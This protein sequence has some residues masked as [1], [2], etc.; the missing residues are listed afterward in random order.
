ML[1]MNSPTVQAMLNSLPQGV[2]NMPVYY[3][4]QPNIST[5]MQPVPQSTGFSSPYPSP[6]DMVM[7]AGS[8]QQTFSPVPFHTQSRFVGGL[9]PN[10]NYGFQQM[11]AG[12]NNPYMGYGSNMGIPYGFQ[13]MDEDTRR[14]YEAA[15]CNNMTYE[16]HVINQSNL[17]KALSRTVS[18]CLNRS[19]EEAER[20]ERAF[21]VKYK[22]DEAQQQQSYMP[23]R[24]KKTISVQLVQGDEVVYDPK[25]SSYIDPN[26]NARNIAYIDHLIEIKNREE[27]SKAVIFQ[28]IHNTVPESQ[29]Y[30]K[31][32]LYFMNNAGPVLY[33]SYVEK[34]LREQKSAN[35]SALYNREQFKKTL[36][37]NNGIK[38]KSQQDAID[39][40]AGRQGVLPNG[41][42]VSPQHN[43]AI[44]SSFNYN[45]NT[46]SFDITP[47][48]FIRDKL[49]KARSNF[50]RSIENNKDE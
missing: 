3:G 36:F 46:G 33:K 9:N 45:P 12:Y 30:D 39:R 41:M 7:Q 8:Q 28:N 40:F 15:L 2:G 20:C 19:E 25:G 48:N 24:V 37:E 47:P 35:A 18:K 6:K 43:P 17:F 31:D 16:E 32:F 34:V 13:T 42:L 27:Y 49:E 21:D 29:F 14:V 1:N 26:A 38:T 10:P 5:E 4:N 23:S 11:F 22:N 44:S 50:M